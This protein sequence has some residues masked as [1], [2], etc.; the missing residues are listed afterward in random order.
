[1]VD[2]QSVFVAGLKD[3]RV[4]ELCEARGAFIARFLYLLF[5][6]YNSAS[7]T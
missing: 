2:E 4:G 7:Y 5:S 1:L 3:S 6:K